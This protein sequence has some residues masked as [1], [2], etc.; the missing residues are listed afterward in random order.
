MP[1]VDIASQVPN[2]G[3]GP[4]WQI[5]QSIKACLSTYKE[6]CVCVCVCVSF[7]VTPMTY[8]GF[9]ARGQIRAVA[10]GLHHS[11]SNTGSEPC[12]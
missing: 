2:Y 6:S 5:L 8:G 4:L 1:F 12:L 9:Q 11:H 7:M 3:D 10:S